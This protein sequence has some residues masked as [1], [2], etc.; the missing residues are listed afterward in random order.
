MLYGVLGVV[1]FI[2]F[3]FWV[4]IGFY[5]IFLEFFVVVVDWIF[6]FDEE[7]FELCF[8]DDFL[9]WMVIVYFGCFGGDVMK[10]VWVGFGLMLVVFWVIGFGF[11]W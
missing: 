5:F 8:V 1:F 6:L 3:F 2:L 11:W 10:V 4:V 7:S 9:Y